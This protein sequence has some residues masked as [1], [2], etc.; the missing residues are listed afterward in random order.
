MGELNLKDE[1]ERIRNVLYTQ[2]LDSAIGD[3][4]LQKHLRVEYNNCDKD[5]LVD[6]IN[7]ILLDSIGS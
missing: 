4:E 1:V 7:D 6:A 2:A 3:K 5:K